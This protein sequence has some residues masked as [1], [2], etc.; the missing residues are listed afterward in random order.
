MESIDFNG[1]L[2]PTSFMRRWSYDQLIPSLLYF[3]RV[4]FLMDDIEGRYVSDDPRYRQPGVPR[5]RLH[6]SAELA[7]VPDDEFIDGLTAEQH[8]YYW[9][10]RDLMR[11]HVIIITAKG[12]RSSGPEEAEELRALALALVDQQ[13][14]QHREAI[15]YQGAAI[16]YFDLMVDNGSE[17]S[18]EEKPRAVYRWIRDALQSERSGWQ[19]VMLDPSAFIAFQKALQLFPSLYRIHARHR[20]ERGSG[21]GTPET[22]LAAKVTAD[23]LQARLPTYAVTDPAALS[24]ILTVRERRRSE[25]EAFRTRMMEAANELQLAQLGPD[26]LAARVDGY[27]RKLRPVFDETARALSDRWRVPKLVLR[28]S[29]AVV[30]AGLLVGLGAAAGSVVAGPAGGLVGSALA[31][32]TAAGANESI[33]RLFADVG[34]AAAAVVGTNGGPADASLSFLF[35]AERAVR[36]STSQPS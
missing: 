7:G 12:F 8:R 6:S 23:L 19:R 16:R 28:E 32:A 1:F 9:P 18:V 35:H 25:L 21:P 27:V 30:A 4:T 5:V 34:N 20:F 10:M 2:M 3:D 26:E 11:E 22:L 29:G 31:G 13:H 15:D 17:T 24:E 33:K 36:R 14:P